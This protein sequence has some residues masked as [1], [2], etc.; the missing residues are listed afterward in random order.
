MVCH[1][2]K[3]K[4]RSMNLKNLNTAEWFSLSRVIAF[5]IVLALIFLDERRTTAWFYTI[6]FTTDFI[7]GFFAY[8]FNMESKRRAHLDSLGDN[9][10]L[11][12]GFLAFFIFEQSFFIDHIGWISLLAVLYITQLG[13]SLIKYGRPSVFHTYMAKI[14]T[15]IQVVFI[16]HMLFFQASEF[17]FYVALIAS[18]MEVIEEMFMVLSLKKWKANVSG[19]WEAVKKKKSGQRQE[20]L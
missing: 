4:S 5:P 14:A 18:V 1:A 9:L 12:A 6:M 2:L 13:L 16:S 20:E 10:F 17:L 11:L 15:F 19:I 3:N 8:F 7:D